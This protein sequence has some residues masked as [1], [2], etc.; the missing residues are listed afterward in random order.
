MRISH[1]MNFQYKFSLNLLF[2]PISTFPYKKF[3]TK[4]P[5]EAVSHFEIRV[6]LLPLR[7]DT[8]VSTFLH[9]VMISFSLAVWMGRVGRVRCQ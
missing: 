5:C 4:F 7:N 1:E 2:S 3:P 6:I 9:R 8:C